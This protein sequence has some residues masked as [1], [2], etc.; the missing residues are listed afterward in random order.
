MPHELRACSSKV[1]C[2][3]QSEYIGGQRLCV[4][5]SSEIISSK[6]MMEDQ[7]R[8]QRKMRKIDEHI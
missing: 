2:C 5:G 3:G 7:F 8:G 6:V 4:D 1:M